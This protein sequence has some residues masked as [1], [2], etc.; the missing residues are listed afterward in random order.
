MKKV[1]KLSHDKLIP[2]IHELYVKG[3]TAEQI[4]LCFRKHPSYNELEFKFK[5]MCVNFI[6][7]EM[8]ML[9]VIMFFRS[10]QDKL[11]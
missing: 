10:N 3:Y 2:F 11:L 5:E 1:Y 9:Y 8:S 4:K 6:N 7:E